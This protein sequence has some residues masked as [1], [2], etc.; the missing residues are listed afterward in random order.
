ML[1]DELAGLVI[2]KHMQEEVNLFGSQNLLGESPKCKSIRTLKQY[3]ISSLK[4][5]VTSSFMES[6]L[7][8]KKTYYINKYKSCE[9][10]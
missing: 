2:D 5:L 7:G 10:N 1:P 4:G 8:M 3:I 9:C 6:I